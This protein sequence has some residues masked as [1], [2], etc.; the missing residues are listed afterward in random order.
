MKYFNYKSTILVFIFLFGVTTLVS[1]S[2]TTTSTSS[3]DIQDKRVKVEQHI[4]ALQATS[5]ACS[6]LNNRIDKRLSNF[7][8]IFKKHVNNYNK[9]VDKL[10]IISSKLQTAGKDV[11]KLNSDI[12]ILQVKLT[13]FN[14]DKLAVETALNNAK[15]SSCGDLQGQFKGTLDSV[16]T[17]QVAVKA[18]DMDISNFIKNVLRADI[19]AFLK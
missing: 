14:L 6:N 19:S 7:G 8:L 1:A 13:K 15:Q 9:H 3:K 18:D 10:Q 5:T 16:R 12:A 11:S 2:S 17:A 4:K